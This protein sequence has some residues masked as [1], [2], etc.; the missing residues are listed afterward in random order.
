[1]R[2]VIDLQSCQNGAAADPQAVLAL[3][4]ALV[5]GA[6]DH[7]VVIA[8]A[9]RYPDAADALRAAFAGLLAPE[10]IVSYLTPAGGTPWQQPAAELIRDAFFAMQQADVVLAP[11]LFDRPLHETICGKGPDGVL[12]AY[13]VDYAEAPQ[14]ALALHQQWLMRHAAVVLSGDAASAQALADL[15]PLAGTADADA[16]AA[17]LWRAF[18]QALAARPAPTPAAGKPRLAYISPLP[19][20]HS[21]IADYS[22]EVIAE[23]DPYYEIELVTGA[24]QVPDPALTARWPLRT[25]DYFE[26]HADSY[27]HVLYHF[28][29]SN[30]H[31][32]MF[33]LLKRRPGVVVLHDFFLSGVID[34]MERDGVQPQAFLQALY[35][36]HGYTGLRLNAVSGRDRAIWTYPCNKAVLDHAVGIIVHSD[37]SRQ[38]A[39]QWYGPGSADAWRVLPHLRGQPD[40]RT[41]AQ[42]R[43]EARAA[44]GLADDS[45]LVTSFGV[46]GTTKLNQRLLSAFL[47]SP[48][49]RD[50]RCRLVFVGENDAGPYGQELLRQIAASEAAA[51]IHITGFASA[52]DYQCYLAASDAA[53]QLRTKTR[54]ETSGSVLDCLVHGVPTIINA[55]GAAAT[56]PDH[57]LIKLPDQFDDAELSA[58]LAE[59]HGQPAR[60]AALAEAGR[61]HVRIHHAPAAAG[62]QYR[63]ALEHFARHSVGAQYRAL[64][65]GLAG[66]DAAPPGEPALIAAAGAIAANRPASTPRQLLVD[67][68]ALIQGD[69][70]TGIQRVVRSIVLALIEAPPAGYRIEPVYS[71]GANLSYRYARTFTCAMLGGPAPQLEDAPIEVRNGDLF[72]GLDLATNVTTQNQAQLLRMRRRG[73]AI[74]FV[75]YDLLVLQRPGDFPYGALKYYNDYLNTVTLVADGVVS[76][77]RAVSD[78]LAEWLASRPNRRVTP[79]QLGHFHLGADINAS[80]PS[81]G[82]PANAA[83]VMHALRGAPTL[84]M[85]GTLEPRKGQAQA[86]AACELLWQRGVALNLVIVGKNGW[87]VDALARKLEQHPQR[88]RR[89]FWLAGVSDQMLL[90]LYQSSAA[91]L[92]ASEGEGFGLPLIEAAQHGLP[93]IAR[94]L[95]VFR[96]VAGEHAYYFDGLEAAALADA[97]S[98]W[99]ALHQAGQAPASDGMP[100]LTWQQSA[101]QLI[102]V[103]V[104]GKVQARYT[105]GPLAPQLL[106]DVSAVARE[107]LRTGIQRVVRA[108]LTELLAGASTAYRVHPVYLTDEGG[109][110]HYRYAHRYEHALAGTSS[111]NII[112]D[113]VRVTAGDVFYSPDF[114]PGPVNEAARAGL[115]TRWRE[116]GV[117][118]NFLVHDLLPVLR[119]E[120]FPPQSGDVFEGWLRTVAGHADRL[121]CISAA[122]A[123]ELADWLRRD[124][125]ERPLPQLAVLHHGADID[126][127]AP[128]SGLAEDAAAVLADLR[129][130]PSFVMVGTIEPRKGHWQ[131][132]DAFEQ[133]WT[134]GADVRLAVV[135]GEGWRGLPDAQRRTIPAIIARLRGHAELGR[136][137]H[138][139]P[140]ISDE[141][142]EQVYGACDCLLVPSEGEGFGLPLIEAARHGL[143]VIARDIAVFREVAGEHAHYFDGSDGTALAASVRQWLALRAAG[144]APASTGMP[145]LTWSQNIARLTA[146]LFPDAPAET[147]MLRP[148]VPPANLF[149]LSP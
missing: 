16:D 110:W 92:A 149:P 116:A 113:A 148:T 38:L 29:N 17:L 30:A 10:R 129:D 75:L 72:I 31:Q 73:V 41:P 140:G 66:I 102:D 132:L 99:L 3:A 25:P 96:E 133:L 55:H 76:I 60:R 22:A 5:R 74:W 89:L 37:F 27:A 107:D 18:E 7:T 88:E 19:P 79:L 117:S 123:D 128:S 141:Y 85:V 68:S 9:E 78:Q 126:A 35:E 33:E 57:T 91:L 63:D 39:E 49:V 87:L 124:A 65:A 48:L 58:A 95:P 143:P 71:V 122:V 111:E 56:L 144:Q 82:M 36:S 139:L 4:Q 53:V 112:D 26:Q 40:S 135:G 47:A 62:R 34:N 81:S 101:A 61:E 134:E 45:F 109:H 118:V 97:I 142:L 64:L 44:L 105:A 100:W 67:I 51:R 1:M 20:E 15:P 131:A 145:W 50:P 11:G 13:S 147:R 32:Y 52:A 46:L 115:Y 14:G 59:L 106:V 90:Q 69:Y 70:K 137:L 54:G 130:A 127:S 8:L 83:H 23:L 24:G 136:R 2:L 108:Q 93:I 138:W 104:H 6:G 98:A 103:T 43:S 121:I 42:R 125:P 77:S 80:A 86:L 28:G 114:F 21:G 94:D 84:L 146:L 12:L 119:P 120:F